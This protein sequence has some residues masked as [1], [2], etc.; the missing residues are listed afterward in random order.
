MHR[1]GFIPL[2][3]VC[4]STAAFAGTLKNGT[5][6]PTGCGS[7]SDAPGIDDSSIDAYNNSIAAIN[8]WEQASAIYFNCLVNEANQD[9]KTISSSANREQLNH[10]QIL[11]AIKASLEQARARF[12]NR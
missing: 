7:L 10:Q 3:L 4:L 1:I 6:S 12:S 5:W 11:E 8:N 9:N 2:I